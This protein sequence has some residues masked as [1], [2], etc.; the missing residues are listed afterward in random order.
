[1]LERW[2]SGRRRFGQAYAEPPESLKRARV[3]KELP[4]EAEVVR[5]Q[6][7]QEVAINIHIVAALRPDARA[8]WLT[9]AF[10]SV[11]AGSARPSDVY[12]V[13]VHPRFGAG[14]SS[15]LAQLM[16]HE[17]LNHLELFPEKPA[18][19]IKGG[20]FELARS[21]ARAL[22]VE[23]GKTRD[24]VHVASAAKADSMMA[25][26]VDFV[27]RNETNIVNAHALEMQTYHVT[28]KRANQQQVW[29][30]SWGRAAF[31]AQR[32]VIETIVPDSVAGHW[33]RLRWEAGE[34]QMQVGDELIAV[35]GQFG[36]EALGHIKDFLEAILT[37]KRGAPAGEDIATAAKAPAIQNTPESFALGG[38]L[39]DAS[40][41]DWWGHIG[42]QWLYSKAE[43]VY[44]H[45]STKKLVMED[46]S[47]PGAFLPLDT[48]GKM[49][50]LVNPE[51]LE[52]QGRVRWF[53]RA[54]GFGFIRSWPEFPDPPAAGVSRGA[55]DD[56]GDLEDVFVH[57]SE[58]ANSG[59]DDADAHSHGDEIRGTKVICVVPLTPGAPVRF[60]LALQESGKLC[61]SGVSIMSDLA[62]LCSVGNCNG[63]SS[64]SVEKASV[65][66]L[67]ATGR[68]CSA[69]FAGVVSGRRGADGA[70]FVAL[71]LRRH[72]ASCL[73]G[74]ERRPGEKGAK[75]GMTAALRQTQT[76]FL[77]YARRL[78]DNSAR[79]WLATETTACVALVFGP[80]ADG[81]ARVLLATVGGGRALVLRRN[82]SIAAR[83]GG[84]AAPSV[85][86]S[87]GSSAPSV[88]IPTGR[89]ADEVW[90]SRRMIEGSKVAEATGLANSDGPG[91]KDLLKVVERGLK[92]PAISFPSIYDASG[93]EPAKP[94]RGF[95]VH[96][97]SEKDGGAAG[98]HMELQ[99]HI[100][101]WEEDALLL[102]ASERVWEAFRDAGDAEAA[103]L[104]M[105]SL[106][107]EH[108][109]DSLQRAAQRVME[110]RASAR[111]GEDSAIAI[112]R[113]SWCPLD[114]KATDAGEPCIS[115]ATGGRETQP[116]QRPSETAVGLDDVGD[117]FAMPLAS[118][119]N[120][121]AGAP[122]AD[123]ADS[124]DSE[125]ATARMPPSRSKAAVAAPA[126]APTKAVSGA[127]D[128][129]DAAF[130]DFMGQLGGD[131]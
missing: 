4:L 59:K 52:T 40:G 76:G 44:F 66:V 107:G 51:A 64:R 91:S 35:N 61:A 121:V 95:G 36:W 55:E 117:M 119:D 16:M 13:V 33:N 108:S 127:S 45:V 106:R 80:E 19:A 24:S 49:D 101:E 54:K 74:R 57:R 112:M 56:E 25:R 37:F 15:K 69:A 42:G 12:D 73:Q 90:A 30:L 29:G 14:V 129:L 23:H 50:A 100:L 43:K 124:S 18:E 27:K 84:D 81:K 2:R 8:R 103:R 94:V 46:P 118:P 53:N 31:K 99:T 83:L 130:A 82:G 79:Q 120:A 10:E 38:Y 72:L 7:G 78:D 123:A 62:T 48:D 75:V 128:E 22:P 9:M 70:E 63:T 93:V 131:S 3:D 88:P 21:A 67:D 109:P 113:F 32:R 110:A 1:M 20:A 102:I 98:L 77:D 47:T 96:A 97:W 126:A 41:S 116:H 104:V 26:C 71:H 115:S 34:T 60:E 65:D 86:A 68:V 85:G 114:H 17:L 89:T 111:A 11:E 58:V 6:R 125:A 105:Q 5:R 87:T 28:L 39:P 122:L 92:G